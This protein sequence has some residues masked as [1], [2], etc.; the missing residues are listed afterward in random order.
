M[1][2]L[3][4]KGWWREHQGMEARWRR[5]GS[6]W[7]TSATSCTRT[8]TS[9][10]PATTTTSRCSTTVVINRRE[11]EY[12]A[13]GLMG[14]QYPAP[15]VKHL[16]DRLHDEGGALRLLDLELVEDEE[17]IPGVRCQAA[18]GHT[19][20]STNVLVET[21]EGTPASAGTS[22]TTSSTS[23]SPRTCSGWTWTRPSRATTAAASAARRAR[24]AG[25]CAARGTS[26][27]RTTAPRS[28]STAA[29]SAAPSTGSRGPSSPTT[30]SRASSPP[31][32]ADGDRLTGPADPH[33]RAAAM[34]DGDDTGSPPPGWP[35]SPGRRPASAAR[36]PASV[37]V[38]GAGAGLVDGGW[39]AD[40][41]W[42]RP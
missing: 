33:G 30:S 10:T 19:E 29:S 7:R 20:G 28:S 27:P 15:Y 6:R 40:G 14:E 23:S 22:S 24:S 12:S 4:M 36:S 42:D 32:P 41:G 9:T 16:I 5:T 39:V 8:C 21:D 26:C 3:G 17:I 35:S 11:L 37:P 2:N 25:R 1:G 34:T 38:D 18:G 13:S 31:T